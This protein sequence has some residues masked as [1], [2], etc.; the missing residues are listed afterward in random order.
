MVFAA[1]SPLGSSLL[2]AA[3]SRRWLARAGA[4]CLSLAL[5]A[6]A[7][8]VLWRELHEIRPADLLAQARALG[9]ERILGA[10]ALAAGG[11]MVVGLNEWGALRWAGVRSPLRPTLVTSFIATAFANNLGFNLIV[12]G[13]IRARLYGRR[14]ADLTQV[15]AVTAYA[16]VSFWLG[17]CAIS[18]ISLLLA[19]DLAYLPAHGR[20]ALGWLLLLAPAMYLATAGGLRRS[21][22][23]GGRRLSL[24]RPGWAVAQA[25][26]GMADV[27]VATGVL[28]LLLPPGAVSLPALAGV[29]AVSVVLGLLSGVP[30]GAGVFEAAVVGLIPGVAAAPLAAALLGY[31]LIYYL[32]PLAIAA[33]TLPRLDPEARR[34]LARVRRALAE[35]AP[36]LAAPASFV[37]GAALIL[38]GAAPITHDHL[39]ALRQAVPLS[40]L[41]TAH[42]A[43]LLSGLALMGASTGLWRRRAAARELAAWAAAAGAVTALARGFDWEPS[44]AG[45]ALAALLVACPRGFYRRADPR[46]NQLD[47]LT[48][49]GVIAV[50]VG[51]VALGLWCYQSTPFDGSLF[52]HVGYHADPARFLRGS[53]LLG[54]AIL[55]IGARRLASVARPWSCTADPQELEAI[56]PL[57]EASPTTQARLAL[58]GDKAVFADAERRAFIMWAAQGRSLVAMGDPVGDREA[59]RALLWRFREKADQ[60]DARTVFYQVSAERLADYLDLGLALVKLGEEAL[61]PLAD[62]SLEGGPRRNLRQSHA[63]AVRGGLVFELV[64]PP[65]DVALLAELAPISDAWLAERRLAEMGFSLGRF[66]PAVLKRDPIALVRVGGRLVAFANV[67]VAGGVEASIDLMRH[68]PDAPKGVMEF[69]LVELMLWAKAERFQQFNLGMAPLSGLAEHR[70]APLWHK[71]GRLLARRGA[72]FYGFEGLR[73]FKQKFDP[74]WLPRYLAAPP[75]QVAAAALDVARLVSPTPGRCR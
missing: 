62:F 33:A 2:A 70:L 12:G 19:G 38:T 5:L 40:V 3:P 9:P 49:I 75:R 27:T 17:I 36:I 14:G 16:S 59:G 10:A 18:G 68:L 24:P 39:P 8:F 55:L 32:A 57:V 72:R 1:D 7:L 74:T 37:L 30:G 52:A 34:G 6:A 54:A 46:G 51:S 71:L 4:A 69:L 56:A 61:V 26:A 20:Q 23:I 66:D 43:S 15:A 63:R 25:V 29:Y 21:V 53:A 65:I 45:L 64:K 48:D 67:W 50:F 47:R 13:A 22:R 35:I 41:E 42:L 31:R 58:M 73:A 60:T 11:Y 44:L 28:W